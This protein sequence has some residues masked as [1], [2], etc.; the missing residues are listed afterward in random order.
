MNTL[1]ISTLIALI[2]LVGAEVM[3]EEPMAKTDY[4]K[5]IEQLDDMQRKVTMHDGTEPPFDNKYWN[6]HDEGIYVDIISG[7]PLFSSTDK[8]DSGT[9]W[10]SFTQ[11]IEANFVS[12]HS[13]TKLGMER[14]EVRAEDSGA[15]LGHVFNDGPADKGGKRYCINSA[16]L[17]F[18]PK[19]DLVKEGYPQYLGLFLK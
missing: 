6:N 7:K 12:K 13:D 8:F 16:A 17:R 10:P 18:I 2:A 14:T 5:Q 11:P 19:A 9:G 3:A 15:H 1:Y 4:S